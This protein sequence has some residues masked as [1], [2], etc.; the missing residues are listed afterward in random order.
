MFRHLQYLVLYW[1]MVQA[2]Y[3]G[4]HVYT[5]LTYKYLKYVSDI[6]FLPENLY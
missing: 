3:S 4:N 6:A 5:H 1:V 2:Q